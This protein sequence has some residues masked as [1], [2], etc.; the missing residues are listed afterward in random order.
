[1]S[2][3]AIAEMLKEDYERMSDEVADKMLE[4]FYGVE[5]PG[6][7]EREIIRGTAAAIRRRVEKGWYRDNLEKS[8]ADA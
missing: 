4:T 5:D 3:E 8:E 2:D 6:V 1:M 7:K